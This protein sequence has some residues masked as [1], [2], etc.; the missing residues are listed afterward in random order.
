MECVLE[1]QPEIPVEIDLSNRNLTAIY[2]SQYLCLLQRVDLSKNKLGRNLS[3]L[4]TL[5]SC[6]VSQKVKTNLFL[7]KVLLVLSV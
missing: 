2:H 3:A 4:F 5:L 1:R 6:E 7:K